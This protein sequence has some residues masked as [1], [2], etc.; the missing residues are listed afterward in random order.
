MK[1]K[2]ITFKTAKLAKKKGFFVE[3]NCCQKF[4]IN[5]KDDGIYDKDNVYQCPYEHH[6]HILAP[7]QSLLQKWLRET[8]NIVVQVSLF[9]KEGYVVDGINLKDT[10]EIIFSFS[11][12][13]VW[14]EALEKGLRKALTQI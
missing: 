3:Y 1:E 13:D 9:P 14:E 11:N 4:Y 8:H 2:L 10:T 5:L 12:Y 6:S 7:T